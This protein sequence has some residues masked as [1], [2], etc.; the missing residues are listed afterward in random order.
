MK[1][2]YLLLFATF[3]VAFLN[4]QISGNQEVVSSS[5]AQ[6]KT[7]QGSLNFTIGEV[8]IHT[9]SADT[10][11]GIGL[12]QGFHQTYFQITEVTENPMEDFQVRVWP[13]P[14]LRYLNIDL[15]DVKE[16]AHIKAEILDISGVKLELFN[17]VEKPQ[18]DL[19]TYPVSSY[20]LRIYNTKSMSVRMFKII[21][22]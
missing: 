11:A 21:K 13:N 17:V 5:G 22:L 10:L 18:I 6:L 14:T 3:S 15:D 2:T 16:I 9:Y 19:N 8:G 7:S 12:T 1:A 4:A 20:F